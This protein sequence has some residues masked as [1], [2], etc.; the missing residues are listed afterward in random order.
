MPTQDP[1]EGNVY[2]SKILIDEGADDSII[3]LEAPMGLMSNFQ[4]GLKALLVDHDN[5]Q[6]SI[7]SLS[8]DATLDIN[9]GMKIGNFDS[10][11]VPT[12]DNTLLGS[13]YY[14]TSKN[15]PYVCTTDGWLYF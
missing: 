2:R 12:C 14:D 8:S 15:M 5:E 9:G 3:S 7:N 6:V 11:S 4:V 13:I 1:L 10:L